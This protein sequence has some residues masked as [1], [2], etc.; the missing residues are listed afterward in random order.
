MRLKAKRNER[1]TTQ[2]KLSIKSVDVGLGK[3]ICFR[4]SS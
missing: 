2:R 1:N 3:E 4:L